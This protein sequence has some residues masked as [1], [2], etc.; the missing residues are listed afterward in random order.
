LQPGADV[1]VLLSGTRAYEEAAPGCNLRGDLLIVL[2]DYQL[3]A[4]QK[5]LDWQD[6]GLFDEAGVGKT[7][8]VI[9]AALHRRAPRLVTMPAY[10][11]PQFTGMIHQFDREL[12]V[13]TTLGD[14]KGAKTAALESNADFILASYHTWSAVDVGRMRYPQLLNRS[15]GAYIFDESHRIRGRNS[16]WTKHIFKVRNAD[17]KNRTTPIWHMTGTPLVRGPEDVWPFLHL[18]NRRAYNGFW[19]WV[20]YWC[21]VADTPWEPIIGG[22]QP[23]RGP[24]FRAMMQEYS[25][26]RLCTDIPQLAGLEMRFR[27]IP[28]ELPKSVYETMRVLKKRYLLSH[29]ELENDEI[30]EHA[31]EVQ[32]ELRMMT[33]LP[34]TAAKPKLDALRGYLE[35]HSN[36]RL[37]IFAWHQAVVDAALEVLRKLQPK[38]PAFQFDGRTSTKNKILAQEGY[39]EHEDA[40]IVATIAAM[41]AGVNLQQGHQCCFIEES[42]L[43]GENEQAV[44][45]MLRRGQ[46][47]PVIVTR[48]RAARSVDETVWKQSHRRGNEI[49]NALGENR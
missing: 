39:A 20:R 19:D 3:K 4:E 8:P 15:W 31:G 9:S 23:G 7:F 48:I 37:I 45:R 43:P 42:Y 1:R 25:M 21:L 32:A 35:D 28:V 46:T 47:R 13:A 49:R 33:T 2:D 34:P 30:F 11:I 6:W 10:L 44:K 26:R 16:T 12:T 41:N 36:E 17:S 14:G 38:R 22:L 27:D 29:P 5:L 40:V 24:E 18:C